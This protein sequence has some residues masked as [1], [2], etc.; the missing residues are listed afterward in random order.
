TTMISAPPDERDRDS[1]Q[2]PQ[3]VFGAGEVRRVA[4]RRGVAPTE[5]SRRNS[6]SAETLRDL[7]HVVPASRVRVRPEDD[8]T[9]DEHGE[10]LVGRRAA[11]AAR[12][13]P[14]DGTD[15]KNSPA[16]QRVR[17]LLAFNEHGC[18]SRGDLREPLAPVQRKIPDLEPSKAVVAVAPPQAYLG[19]VVVLD[20]LVHRDE[21]SGSVAD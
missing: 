4:L 17:S 3:L 21:C 18:R 8:V 12:L 5:P 7:L 11:V 19:P 16:R 9:S 6:E 15:G 14:R 2:H 10:G 1:D 13:R 20:P